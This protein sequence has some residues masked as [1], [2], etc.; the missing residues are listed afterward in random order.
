MCIQTVPVVTDTNDKDSDT[1]DTL[2]TAKQPEAD[3][4]L[5][6]ESTE[7]KKSRAKLLMTSEQ[8]DGSINWIRET[9]CLY[10]KGLRDYRDTKKRS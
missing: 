5:S 7:K 8:E 2:T 10:Q 3:E 4:A 1:S 6:Q 9:P